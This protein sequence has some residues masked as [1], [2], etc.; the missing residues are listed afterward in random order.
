MLRRLFQRLEQGVERLLRQHVHF[1]DQVD[2]DPPAAGHVLRVVDH[3]AHV[4]DAGI[5]GRVDLEQVDEPPRVDVAARI[6]L[7]AGLGGGSALAIQRLGEDAG[8]GGLAHPARAG[9]EEGVMHPPRIE[10]V[11]ERTH[12]VLLADQLGKPPGPPL[13][14]KDEIGH[15]VA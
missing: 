3:F 4:V 11:G 12:H 6:A 14:R 5:A 15:G 2:L 9:E 7:A 1:V 8:D 13:P 10:R